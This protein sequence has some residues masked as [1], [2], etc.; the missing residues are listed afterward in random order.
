[1]R[2]DGIEVI[3]FHASFAR[4]HGEV[5]NRL[6]GRFGGELTSHA[7]PRL[8]FDARHPLIPPKVRKVLLRAIAAGSNTEET[9]DV[10][11]ERRTLG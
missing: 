10:T 1:M 5:F 11:F 2:R 3:A 6:H 4:D 8:G 9:L 7:E